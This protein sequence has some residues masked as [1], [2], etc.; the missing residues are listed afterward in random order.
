MTSRPTLSERDLEGLCRRAFPDRPNQRIGAVKQ[1]HSRQHEMLAFQLRWRT[2]TGEFDEELVV[3]RY[4]STLSWW[5]PDDFGKAQR[6]AT[7]TPWLYTHGFPVP[8]VYAREFGALGD[9]VLFSRVPGQD[10]REEPGSFAEIVRP[11]IDRFAQM[12][13]WLHS[14]EPPQA[15]LEVIPSVTLPNALA[16]LMALAVKIGEKDLI[17]AVDAVLRHAFTVVE[18]ERVVLH[19]DYHFSNTLLFDG[20]IS[21]IIDWEYCALGDPRWDVANAYSQLVDFDAASVADDFLSAYLRHSGRE[22]AGPP[23]YMVAV[24]LQQWMVAEWLMKEQAEGRAPGFAM[25]QELIEL[26]DVHRRR[27]QMA[28]DWL[29][30]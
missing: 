27:A 11:H 8:A 2:N 24:P 15:V 26:R 29:N 4:I 25:A 22:F 13:V 18:T 10:W 28:M 3:R 30:Q 21:G 17:A 7:V 20:R 12:L 6:E 1:I 23:L 5:R 19:G 14:L 9:I 16:N